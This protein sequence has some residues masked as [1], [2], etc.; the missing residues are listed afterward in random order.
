MRS[1]R[2]IVVL[3]VLSWATPSR[4]DTRQERG[5]ALWEEG[6]ARYDSGK[7]DEAIELFMRAYELGLATSPQ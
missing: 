5:H 7:F 4:A 3:C 1:L 2:P 6:V